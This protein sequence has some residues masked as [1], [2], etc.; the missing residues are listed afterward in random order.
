MEILP[1]L[2]KGALEVDGVRVPDHRAA[3]VPEV[4]AYITKLRDKGYREVIR[5]K[6]LDFF[7]NLFCHHPKQELLLALLES[8]KLSARYAPKMGYH[9]E[10]G[11]GEDCINAMYP[12][13]EERE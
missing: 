11:R 1:D 9:S 4:M 5:R 13:I 7:P 8:L 12:P 2:L 6:S 10:R 3:L